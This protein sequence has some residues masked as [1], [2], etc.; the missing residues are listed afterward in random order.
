MVFYCERAVGFSR[1]YGLQDTGYFD[2][3]VR[4]FEQAL[5]TSATLP[6]R[7]Q[8]DTMVARRDLAR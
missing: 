6:A 7:Q 1:E 8:R 2:A 5:K 4:M 3:L